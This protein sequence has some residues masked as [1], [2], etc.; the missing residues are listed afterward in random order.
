MA[1]EQIKL[2]S[3]DEAEVIVAVA[4]DAADRLGWPP[5]SVSSSVNSQLPTISTLLFRQSLSY[6][7]MGGSIGKLM[8][9][10]SPGTISRD[11]LIKLAPYIDDWLNGNAPPFEL[12]AEYD[13]RIEFLDSFKRRMVSSGVWPV[14]LMEKARPRSA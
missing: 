5:I 1:L 10:F 7:G 2:V 14:G 6:G 9:Y 11:D 4:R 12:P 13:R 8:N 3:D